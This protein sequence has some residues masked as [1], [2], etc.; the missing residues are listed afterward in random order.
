MAQDLAPTPAL[1]PGERWAGRVIADL[2]ALGPSWRELVAHAATATS[3]RPSGRWQARARELLAD[4]GADAF[5]ARAVD[6]L[7]LVGRPRGGAGDLEPADRLSPRNATVLRGLAWLLA[8]VPAHH[9]AARALGDLTESALSRVAGIGPR[10]PKVANAAVY[11]LSRIEGDAGLGQLI[12]LASRIRYRGTLNRIHAALDA[13]ASALGLSRDEVEDLG[14]PT[15]GL[16]EVGR[17]VER[18][19]DV[20][21]EILVSGGHPHL[22]WR[23]ATGATLSSVPAAVRREHTGH[24]AELRGAVK[25][26]GKMLTA[27]R[28]RLDRRFV[29]APTWRFGLWRERYL[30]HPL[31]GT[32]ARRLIWTVNGLAVGYADG[33]LRTIQDVPVR[34]DAGATVGLWHPVG[35]PADEVLAWRDWLERHDVRQPF[36]QAHRE[37]YRMT[38]DEEATRVYSNR[39]AGHVLRQHQFHALAAQRGWRDTLRMARD[40]TAAPA[41]RELPEWGLRVEFWI[42]P[43]D[44]G[45]T[46][47]SGAYR[48]VVTDQIRFYPLT[49]PAQPVPLDRVPPLVFSEIL[50]D[51]D[52][53]VGIASVGSD[54]TWRDGGPQ[55]RYRD[56]W[57]SYRFG[58]LSATA[59]TRRDVLSHLL[60]GLGVGDRFRVQDRFLL[61]HGDLHDYKIH[62]GS[63][64]AVMSPDNE[65]LPIAPEQSARAGEGGAFV[66]FDDDEM[67]RNILGTALLLANDAEIS[68][69]GLRRDLAGMGG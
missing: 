49:G 4:V 32:L 14:I 10:S 21:A 42:A 35:R 65:Y 56:Y 57:R 8:L 27:Q 63:G 25:D 47:E 7:A 41:R 46:F 26:I 69:P 9:E 11:A 50:R 59:Q 31:V 53:A 54:P 45:E 44:D 51:V 1:D 37:V 17:R 12:R 36:K 61:V 23:D 3:A 67:L 38:A 24:L 16:T 20:T 40:D 28:D 29:A 55:G 58:D 52:I 48:Q 6:W 34:P 33:E 13:R 30:D 5:R 62:L 39:F 15:Y 18:V 68:D 66:P 60:A 22:A 64:S 19:G 2:D 43:A